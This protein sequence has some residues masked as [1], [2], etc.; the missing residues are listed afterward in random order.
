LDQIGGDIS[1]VQEITPIEGAP[2]VQVQCDSEGWTIIQS[3]GQFGNKEDYFYREWASYKEG[4]GVAGE[5]NV[6]LF[7]NAGDN[8][9]DSKRRLAILDILVPI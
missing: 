3:R 9:L 7:A 2:K 1:G 5:I 8:V 6:S 4:F